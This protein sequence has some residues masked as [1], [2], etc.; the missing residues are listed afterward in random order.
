MD[1]SMG[2]VCYVFVTAVKLIDE[3]FGTAT[4]DPSEW[5]I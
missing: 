1:W 5:V 2:F 4:D 3:T